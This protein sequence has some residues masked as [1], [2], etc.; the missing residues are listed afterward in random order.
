MADVKTP[1]EDDQPQLDAAAV[2]AFA[3]PLRVRLYYLLEADG[4]ATASGLAERVGESSG[5]TSYHL[6]QLARHGLVVE[7]EG[8]GTAKE[9]WWQPNP[10]GF[11]M[12]GDRLR[13]DPATRAATDLLL[14]EFER[15]KAADRHRWLQESVTAPPDWV[16]ASVD[17]RRTMVLTSV[18]TARL[19][20]EL[21]EVAERY[22]L[23]SSARDLVGTAD[24]EGRTHHRVVMHLE[25]FPLG[26]GDPPSETG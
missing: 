19:S 10:K 4:P 2:R 5:S 26:A 16:E 8:R 20:A 15:R 11:N 24:A 1:S 9:R 7:V 13:A 23:L 21:D 18:E 17:R 3:H 6:R 22:R 25:L 12:R 14:G